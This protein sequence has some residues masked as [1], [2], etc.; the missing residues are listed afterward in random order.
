MERLAPMLLTNTCPPDR[1]PTLSVRFVASAVVAALGLGVSLG[2]FAA[3]CSKSSSQLT[4]GAS[5][6]K[7]QVSVATP[8]A[9]LDPK[10]QAST[11]SVT[12]DAE[13]AWTAS[14]DVNWITVMTGSGQGD[15]QILLQVA[16]N[17]GATPRQGTITLNNQHA[18]V[19]QAGTPC[20][21]T[22]TPLTQAIAPTGGT[23]SIGVATLSGCSWAATSSVP[24]VTITSGASGSANGTV[25]FS[26][27]ANTGVARVGSVTIADQTFQV[28][29]ASGIV[30]VVPCVFT[31]DSMAQS[32]GAGGGTANVTITTDPSCSWTAAGNVTWLTVTGSP[33]GAGPGLLAIAVAANTG[34]ARTGTA[35]IAGQTFTVTETG[36]CATSVAPGTQ[37][38]GAAG[39]PGVVNVT[40]AAG[41][42][43]SAT[44]ADPWLTITAGASGNG[45]GTV[46]F[47]AAANSGAS[48]TG[49]ITVAGQPAS[50]TESGG[51]ASSILPASENIVAGGGAGTPVA[52]TIAAGCAWTATTATPWITITSGASGNGNGTVNFTT[53]AN[54]GPSRSGSISIAGQTLGVTEAGSCAATINP[55]SENLPVGGGAGT[56]VTVTI[57][58]GCAWTATTTDP[59]IS[60]TSG[61]S[62]N[63]NGTVNFTA[64]AN[65]GPSRSGS[66]SIAGQTLAVNEAGNCTASIN[67]TTENVPVG[68]GAGTAV[69]VTIASGCAWTATTSDTWITISSGASGNGNGSVNFNAAANTG[70]PRNGTITIAGQPLTV[71]QASGCSY[72]INPTS[73]SIGSGGGAG[74]Q[75]NVTTATGWYLDRRRQ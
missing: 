24:W 46:S 31:L 22:L 63:G 54:T 26:A 64:T 74:S 12:T 6:S 27:A 18:T 51:C 41:C 10:G 25:G 65:S 69:T 59:W 9:A 36:S 52:V 61:A 33:A 67:P 28:T 5:P 62:G 23:G 72:A 16:P 1:F 48:R 2:V 11:L 45:N 49:T 30:P 13:C 44:T 53:T 38:I 70:P 58:S 20:Q 15:G 68:G 60:V 40:T 75:V 17:P 35:T 37:A 43:W 66:I 14:V 50:I 4:T 7:C 19:T 29:Q 57:T 47:A 8:P 71:S 34:P 39:G 21:F 3:A 42:G 56:A 73:Q 55:T 32:F